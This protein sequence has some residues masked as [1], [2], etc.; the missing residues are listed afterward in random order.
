MKLWIIVLMVILIFVIW[1]IST[2]N[3]LNRY[4]IKIDESLSGIDIALTKRYDILTKM[5]EVVKGYTKH[6][7]EV[8][9]EVI[10]LRKNMNINEIA[11][12]VGIQDYNYFTKLFKKHESLTP[13]AFRKNYQ[14]SLN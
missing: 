7:K 2:Y 5:I 4:I 12:T 11:Y 14:R 13:S 8:L 3:K 6:E 10:K 1:Y 9:F